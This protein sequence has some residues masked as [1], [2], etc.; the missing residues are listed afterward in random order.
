M[1]KD[2]A[3]PI[4]FPLLSIYLLS[5]LQ[6][7]NPS[8][9]PPSIDSLN[10]KC[11]PFANHALN[12]RCE[13]IAGRPK[14]IFRFEPIWAFKADKIKTI[15]IIDFLIPSGTRNDGR[16]GW[17]VHMHEYSFNNS[18]LWCDRQTIWP[19]C[20]FP[21]SAK[22]GGILYRISYNMSFSILYRKGKNTDRDGRTMNI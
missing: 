11:F 21:S 1:S 10:K 6:K 18:G 5:L 15:C 19:R 16:K 20:S 4:L 3:S 8:K 14:F 9:K 2:G 12:L 7:K 13:N 22:E 17:E